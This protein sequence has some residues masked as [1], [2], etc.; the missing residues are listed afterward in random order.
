MVFVGYSSRNLGF[1]KMVRQAFERA[2]TKVLP[3]N[4]SGNVAGEPVFTSVEA[5]SGKANFAVVLTKKERNLAIAEELA[6][7]GITRV[8][9]GNSMC[10]DGAVLEKCAELGLEAVV[11]CPMMALGGGLHRFHGFLAGVR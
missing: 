3:V 9:F 2:G 5:V 1:S 7:A 11:A 6:K 8:A 10:A 4:P